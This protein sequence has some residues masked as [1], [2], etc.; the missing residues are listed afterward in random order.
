GDDVLELAAGVGGAAAGSAPP[1]SWI[2]PQALGRLFKFG[3]APRGGEEG[4][5]EESPRMT[6]SAADGDAVG[7]P[8]QAETPTQGV[9]PASAKDVEETVGRASDADGG[10]SPASTEEAVDLASNGLKTTTSSVLGED[11]D[12]SAAAPGT[13]G[14]DG[15]GSDRDKAGTPALESPPSLEAGPSAPAASALPST[16]ASSRRLGEESPGDKAAAA[17]LPTDPAIDA[18]A[19][20]FPPTAAAGSSSREAAKPLA[21]ATSLLSSGEAGD[22]ASDTA[23]PR[24]PKDAG[25][26]LDVDDGGDDH[27][28]VDAED[29]ASWSP[30][31]QGAAAE[32]TPAAALN[33]EGKWHG[34]VGVDAGAEATASEDGSESDD[35]VVPPAASSGEDLGDAAVGNAA[36]SSEDGLDG[37]GGGDGAALEAGTYAP[38]GADEGTSP[39]GDNSSSGEGGGSGS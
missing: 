33:E 6:T 10:V 24:T 7:M 11:E 20:V 15:D 22:K 28:P 30:L 23:G 9:S 38:G 1:R 13:G 31:S 4:S 17:S 35:R 21:H 18:A 39:G 8:S 37:G 26:V 32:A 3:R 19:E 14:G 12:P 2:R 25:S 36:A 16:E 29:T 34:G 5:Q 27:A